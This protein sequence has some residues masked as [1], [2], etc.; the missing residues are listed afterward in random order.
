MKAAAAAAAAAADAIRHGSR[1]AAAVLTF[2]CDILPLLT[3]HTDG[4]LTEALVTTMCAKHANK[5]KLIIKALL[6]IFLLVML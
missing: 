6:H 2:R 3:T 1:L 5:S 4:I